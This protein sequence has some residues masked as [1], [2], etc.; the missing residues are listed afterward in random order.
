MLSRFL[1]FSQLNESLTLN[2]LFNFYPFVCACIPHNMQNMVSDLL[3][4]YLQ[5]V[6]KHLTWVLETKFSEL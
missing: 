4:I 3:E 1:L 5:V 2:N 6:V